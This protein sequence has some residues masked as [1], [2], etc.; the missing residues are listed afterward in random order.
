M[1]TTING[2]S[3]EALLTHSMAVRYC[4]KSITEHLNIDDHEEILSTSAILHDIGIII[5]NQLF[6]HQFMDLFNLVSP[7]AGAPSYLEMEKSQFGFSHFQISTLFCETWQ[8]SDTVGA[9]LQYHHDF[10][11]APDHLKQSAAILN[12]ADVCALQLHIGFFYPYMQFWEKPIL[13]FL[14]LTA[15]NYTKIKESCQNAVLHV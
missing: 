13:D 2:F 4:V 8:I 5:E 3:G 7:D 14:G 15:A 9:P 12:L 10:T 1:N 11:A 6:H